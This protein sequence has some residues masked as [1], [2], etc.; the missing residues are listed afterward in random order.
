[1]TDRFVDPRPVDRRRDLARIG[2]GAGALLLTVVWFR[3]QLVDVWPLLWPPT[4]PMAA[5]MAL[6]VALS[7]LL[8]M[9]IAAAL[10][11]VLYDRVVE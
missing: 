3:H 7:L 11:D 8:P 4:E 5:T 6:V 1:M 2:A 10:V 9:M